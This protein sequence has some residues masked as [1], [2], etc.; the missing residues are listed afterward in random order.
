MFVHSR[1]VLVL[2]ATA[3][4]PR[5]LAAAEHGG[6]LVLQDDRLRIAWPDAGASP[7]IARDNALR[8]FPR[9]RA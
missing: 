5:K 1:N 9:L 4:E 7:V 3:A 6:S 8:L 2:A